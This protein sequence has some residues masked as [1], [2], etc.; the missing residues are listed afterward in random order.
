MSPVPSTLLVGSLL[1]H[2]L[3]YR[4]RDLS[5][6]GPR[7]LGASGSLTRIWGL[8]RRLWERHTSVSIA[9]APWEGTC[10]MVAGPSRWRLWLGVAVLL[11]EMDFWSVMGDITPMSCFFFCFFCLWGLDI[12]LSECFIAYKVVQCSLY[13]RDMLARGAR[14]VGSTQ[15]NAREERCPVVSMI[16][17]CL[18]LGH[19]DPCV[20]LGW[21]VRIVFPSAG[22]SYDFY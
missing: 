6:E 14:E 7:H 3:S 8:Q 4:H 5:V 22:H 11:R 21:A 13:H 12:T 10:L 19:L 20:G 2:S 9:W 15:H 16:L 1:T 18:H 17:S